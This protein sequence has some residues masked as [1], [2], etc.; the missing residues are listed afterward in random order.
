MF[1]LETLLYIDH[2]INVPASG[3]GKGHFIEKK[4]YC[5][6]QLVRGGLEIVVRADALMLQN[7]LGRGPLSPLSGFK[8]SQC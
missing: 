8:V 2:C 3:F 1:Y 7:S 4:G 6:S 5:H